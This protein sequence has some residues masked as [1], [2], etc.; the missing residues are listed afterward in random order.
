MEIIITPFSVFELQWSR[1]AS[2]YPNHRTHQLVIHSW[3]MLIRMIETFLYN[4]DELMVLALEL[5]Y[6][7][8]VK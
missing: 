6:N 2:L 4:L 7:N 5:V 3:Q 8:E 1:L